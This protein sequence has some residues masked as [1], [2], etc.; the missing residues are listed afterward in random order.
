MNVL[1]ISPINYVK[2]NK[3]YSTPSFKARNVYAGDTFERRT[4]TQRREEQEAAKR[5]REDFLSSWNVRKPEVKEKIRQLEGEQFDHVMW[6]VENGMDP[7]YAGQL[8]TLDS[9]QIER[10]YKL[11]D[12]GIPDS[13]AAEFAGLDDNRYQK[14]VQLLRR[15]VPAYDVS[16]IV[17]KTQD[18]DFPL[19]LD[20]IENNIRPQNIEHLTKFPSDYLPKAVLGLA[21]KGVDDN[22]AINIVEK[23]STEVAYNDYLQ[24]GYNPSLAGTL[25]NTANVDETNEDDIAQIL[26]KFSNFPPDE[27]K[28][29]SEI[30]TRYTR[31]HRRDFKEFSQY[32]QNFDLDAILPYIPD[33]FSFK[34]IMTFVDYHYRH[35]TKDFNPETLN[36]NHDMYEFLSDNY[37]NADNIDDLFSAFPQTN[38]NIGEL[39]Q[40]WLE[41]VR[42]PEEAKMNIYDAID[43]FRQEGKIKYFE[44]DLSYILNKDVH[45]KKLGAGCY[46]ADFYGRVRRYLL[47]DF[48]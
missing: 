20:L 17:I 6:L 42:Y 34:N 5:S 8:A 19:I 25:A 47:K 31:K 13:W 12:A 21:Q 23:K 9:R 37:L 29:N 11:L 15:G 44:E 26:V 1:S 2:Y 22:D 48:L 28:S 16:T 45:V 39:P 36:F 7:M 18:K 10:A 38:R 32:I 4:I 35:Q 24:K 27:R 3:T 14:S 41:N 30:L 40:S 46:G 43:R 33:T